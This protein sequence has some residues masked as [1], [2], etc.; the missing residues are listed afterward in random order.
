MTC[1]PTRT[2]DARELDI[3]SLRER[4]RLERDKRVRG[5]GQQQYLRTQ[6]DYAA[7]HV[8]DPHMPLRTRASIA[9]DLDVAIL[10]GGFS[11]LMAGVHLRNA[12]VHSFRHIEHAGDF[13]GVWYWNR[14]P[15]IQCDNDSYCYL[16][17]LEETGFVPSKKFADGYEIQ[18]HCQ[19]IATRYGLYEGALF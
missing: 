12:G 16:P 15:G 18:E 6:D 9:E 19:R 10:G 1:E 4:Y 3:P 2:P 5:E 13:G 7:S 11:G 8:A 14:Y 17:L